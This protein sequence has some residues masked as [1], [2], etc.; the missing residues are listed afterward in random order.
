MSR[1]TQ[2][3]SLISLASIGFAQNIPDMIPFTVTG[4]LDGYVY[5]PLKVTKKLMDKQMQPIRNCV[6]RGGYCQRQ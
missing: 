3:A 6:Q 4:S 2:L 1:L 5:M